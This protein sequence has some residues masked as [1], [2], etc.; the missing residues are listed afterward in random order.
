MFIIN[1]IDYSKLRKSDLK[2]DVKKKLDSIFKTLSIHDKYDITKSNDDYPMF[3][4]LARQK[5]LIKKI[6]KFTIKYNPIN[7]IMMYSEVHFMD[8]QKDQI[9]FMYCIDLLFNRMQKNA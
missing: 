3:K 1:G 8:G 7:K 4:I 5:Y 9:N 2:F 6:K